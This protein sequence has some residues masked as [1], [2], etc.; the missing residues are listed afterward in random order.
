MVSGL[1]KVTERLYQV[2][3][4]D[5]SNMTII[6]GDRGVIVI[7]LWS[8]RRPPR[9]PSSCSGTGRESR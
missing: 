8:P 4:L 7:D 6:E 3:G 2:R 5:L 1:F 9:R